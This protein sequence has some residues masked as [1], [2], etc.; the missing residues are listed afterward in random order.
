[1]FKLNKQEELTLFCAFIKYERWV[2]K[3]ANLFGP[4]WDQSDGESASLSNYFWTFLY[5]KYGEGICDMISDFIQRGKTNYIDAE[6][7]ECPIYTEVD[8]YNFITD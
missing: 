2:L 5:H 6:G 3:V 1:M 7:N 8:L 4:D